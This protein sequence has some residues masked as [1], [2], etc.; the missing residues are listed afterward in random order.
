[1]YARAYSTN[2]AGTGYGMAMPFTT[3]TGI[4]FNTNLTYGSV[5][6]IDGNNYKTIQIGTQTWMAE[7]LKTTK[8]NDGTTIPFETDDTAWSGLT[9]P[10]YCWYNNDEKRYRAPYGALYNWY[11][12]NTGKLCPSGWHVPGYGEW[13]TLAT[14]LGG[15]SVAGGKLKET[16]TTHWTTPNE[17]ATNE[18]GF[19]A[20]AGGFRRDYFSRIGDFGNWWSSSVI[21]AEKFVSYH[22]LN[23]SD[24]RIEYIGYIVMRRDGFSVRCL[25]D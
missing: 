7:N 11:T 10:A 2:D 1:M 15:A 3:G 6:D 14:F 4:I 21:A 18:S 22:K 8:Y 13:M 16:G 5:S 12:V 25:K 17:G 23:Y 24:Y 19:T 9:T 20:L